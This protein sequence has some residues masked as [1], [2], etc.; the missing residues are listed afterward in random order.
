MTVIGSRCQSKTVT[1]IIKQITFI[2]IFRGEHRYNSKTKGEINGNSK[3]WD[4]LVN[5]D[6]ARFKVAGS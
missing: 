2:A 5:F 1:L 3:S 4:L 6:I